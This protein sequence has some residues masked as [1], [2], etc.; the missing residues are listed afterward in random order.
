[1]EATISEKFT[2]SE[3]TIESMA[4]GVVYVDR[5]VDPTVAWIRIRRDEVLSISMDSGRLHP[6]EHNTWHAGITVY[7]VELPKGMSIELRN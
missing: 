3:L 2:E 6:I 5:L 7:G 1:M 4:M